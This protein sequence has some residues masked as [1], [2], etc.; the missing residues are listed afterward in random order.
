MYQ[1]TRILSVYLESNSN[2]DYNSIQMTCSNSLIIL[3]DLLI[4]N[5]NWS[6]EDIVLR[7]VV[8]EVYGKRLLRRKAEMNIRGT[9]QPSTKFNKIALNTL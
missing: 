3:Y 9:K 1:C 6:K 4:P 8:R 2:G 7:A 5:V